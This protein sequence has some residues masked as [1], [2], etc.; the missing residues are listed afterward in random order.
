MARLLPLTSG[1]TSGE[2]VFTLYDLE[3]SHNGSAAA[4]VVATGFETFILAADSDVTV[5]V[6]SDE[7]TATF[8]GELLF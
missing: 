8:K 2:F 7:T 4:S 3:A 1:V 5:S 6:D